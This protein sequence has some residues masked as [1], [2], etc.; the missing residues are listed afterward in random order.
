MVNRAL[1]WLL[2]RSALG[3]VVLAATAHADPGNLHYKV[4]A[5]DAATQARFG[6][7]MAVDGDLMVVGAPGDNNARGAAYLF[8]VSN[9][10]WLA[11]IVVNGGAVGDSFGWSVAVDGN[12]VLVSAWPE[13]NA[14][15]A[16]YTY[17]V[18]DPVNPIQTH[19]LVALDGQADDVFGW[20]V[21]LA[22][23]RAL[24]G[25]HGDSESGFGS[26]SAYIFDATTGAQLAKLL[27]DDG[28]AEA[29]FGFAVAARGNIGLIT[30]HHDPEHGL[31]AGAAYIFNINTGQQRSKFAAT[32]T[33]AGD[34]FGYAAA[35]DADRA[36]ISALGDDDHGEDSGSAIIFDV[37]TLASPTQ[38]AKI[39]APDG[40][41]GQGF[42]QHLAI[43]GTAALVGAHIDDDLGPYAG[44]AYLF[45]LYVPSQ[46]APRVKITPADGGP[47]DQFG[48]AVGLVSGVGLSAA[49]LDDDAAVNAGSVY[50]FDADMEPCFGDLNRDGQVNFAD[51]Q[52]FLAWFSADDGRADFNA[53]GLLDIFDVLGFLNAYADGCV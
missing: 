13:D 35:L 19:R 6:G 4:Y 43:D 42:G 34:W 29:Q 47:N 28:A 23:T 2:V 20:S 16:V 33:T 38:I 21:A 11:K 52:S 51:V 53:D 9:G 18:T 3:T 17:D 10:A 15:G 44:A 24:I 25:A 27:P 36:I 12:L 31:R 45:D 8:R 5:P 30:A 41:S 39:T 46:P 50:A 49:N 7:S 48:Y 26:G 22:G 37:S 40:R 1:R 14:R 32:D